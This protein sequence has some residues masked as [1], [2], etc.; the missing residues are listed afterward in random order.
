MDPSDFRLRTTEVDAI[1]ASIQKSWRQENFRKTAITHVTQIQRI[2]S[3]IF[4]ISIKKFTSLQNLGL[5]HVTS[6]IYLF[7]T[8]YSDENFE[9]GDFGLKSVS[10]YQEGVF[11]NS[12]WMKSWPI[13]KWL[14]CHFGTSFFK[15]FFA[16]CVQLVPTHQQNVKVRAHRVSTFQNRA[17][18]MTLSGHKNTEM[19]SKF[20]SYV[21]FWDFPILKAIGNFQT[22]ISTIMSH[23]SWAKNTK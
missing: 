3:V 20:E 7:F 18:K 22:Q 13:L 19:P 1:R 17:T 15:I 21:Y 16:W 12:F 10:S 8:K 2:F 6:K 9:K 11:F 5:F 14:F 4:G 23:D